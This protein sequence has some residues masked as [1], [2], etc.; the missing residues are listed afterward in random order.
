MKLVWLKYLL[1]F[2][3]IFSLLEGMGI[4]MTSLFDHG[5]QHNEWQSA[6][7]SDED[8]AGRS[9]KETNFKEYYTTLELLQID[10]LCI[11]CEPVEYADQQNN[12]HLAWVSPVPT[13]PPDLLV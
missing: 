9:E 1:V 12:H 7:T 3:C 10:P 5:D 2:V 6:T 4:S 13:P 8:A 11:N